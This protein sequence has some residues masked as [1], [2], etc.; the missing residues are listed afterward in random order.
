MGVSKSPKDVL[1]LGRHLVSELGIETGERPNTLQRWMA[2]HVAELIDKSENSP[3]AADRLK[4]HKDA[5]EIILKIWGQRTSLP[6]NAYPLSAYQDILNVLNCL[7]PDANP[8]AFIVRH[9][10]TT[11]DQLAVEL[12]DSLS[13]LVI[14]LLLMKILINSMS[15]S[16]SKVTLKALN[17]IELNILCNLHQWEELFTAQKKRPAQSR[18]RN[19]SNKYDV[20][21]KI[22]LN[23]AALDLI[24]T[25]TS[26]LGQLRSELSEGNK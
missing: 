2:H 9:A 4:A 11:K 20:A 13:R 23:K 8:F 19:K 6:R 12:F 1:D 7:R 22:D 14:A 5:T 25:I 17:K 24:D 21:Q 18:K 16:T 15:R 10:R 3:V 26:T